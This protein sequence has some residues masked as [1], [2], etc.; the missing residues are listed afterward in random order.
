MRNIAEFLRDAWRLSKPY[1][2]R[3]DERRSAWLLLAAVI[4]MR[5]L[6]VGMEV[7]LSFWNNAFFTSLQEKDWDS[8]IGLLLTWKVTDSGCILPGFCGVATVYIVI[9]VY[10]IYLTQW[11]QI[12]WR[13]WMTR[14][15][16]DEWLADRAYYRISLIPPA[17]RARGIGTENPDQRIAED[18]RAFIGDGVAGVRGILF[19]GI[20]LLSNVVSLFSFIAIL[21][22]L[23]GPLDGA[24]RHHPGLHGVGGAA[25]C[26]R[27]ARWRRI[28]SAGRWRC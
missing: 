14:H 7:V 24:G 21:W 26:R 20:D 10:R 6:L 15:F 18:L 27:S 25:L 17:R 5:L 12:R 23:S 16:L 4:A 1:F 19:L 2:T 28:T 22:S 3:S 9:A 11:L 8:F 13:R